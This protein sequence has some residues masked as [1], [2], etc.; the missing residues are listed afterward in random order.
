MELGAKWVARWDSHYQMVVDNAPNDNNNNI[1]IDS[2][3]DND[4]ALMGLV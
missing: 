2:Y 3:N 1:Y 4:N